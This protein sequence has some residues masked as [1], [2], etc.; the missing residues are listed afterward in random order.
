LLRPRFVQVLA[1]V[2]IGYH[3]YLF[4][5]YSLLWQYLVAIGCTVAAVAALGCGVPRA[6]AS[7]AVPRELV[8][9]RHWLRSTH[10][11]HVHH[12][13]LFSLLV[14]LVSRPAPYTPLTQRL[15]AVDGCQ[16]PTYGGLL[17]LSAGPV[18]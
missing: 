12:Y 3:V 16:V 9:R 8:C 7:S 6:R 4:I 15:C 2:E 5:E 13:I 1:L 11:I 18:P 10:S 14:P 17:S